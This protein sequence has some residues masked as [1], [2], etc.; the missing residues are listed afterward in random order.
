MVVEHLEAPFGVFSDPPFGVF[1]DHVAETK[2]TVKATTMVF[3]I[4]KDELIFPDPHLAEDDGL[5]CI[6]GDLSPERL[7]LAYHHGIFPWFSFRDRHSPHWYCPKQRFVIFPDEI[8]VS[9]SMRTLINKGKYRVS[10]NQDFDGV[11]HGC[12]L[13]QNRIDMEGAWLGDDIIEAYTALHRM[14]WAASV[15]VWDEED[16]LVGGLYGVTVN[17]CFIGESMF[18]LVPS[19]SKL[20]LIGLA[21]HMQDMGWKLIDCQL[22]TPHLRSMGA[23]FIPYDDYMSI[24]TTPRCQ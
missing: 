5:L 1:S 12:S 17:G 11:I 21:Y 4:P 16:H 14:G 3:R 10:I 6:G 8:H 7:I 18:S 13:A 15:E 24:L 19:A 2:Q 23:R 22:E 20:A 9:H